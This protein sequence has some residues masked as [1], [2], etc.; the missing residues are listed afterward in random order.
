MRLL[1]LS[2]KPLYG[3]MNEFVEIL[4]REGISEIHYIGDLEKTDLVPN[5]V[6]APW[7]ISGVGIIYGIK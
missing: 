1:M 6:T 2:Q 7:M 4:K 3:D 5:F